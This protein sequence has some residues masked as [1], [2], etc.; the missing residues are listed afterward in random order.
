MSDLEFENKLKSLQDEVE[1]ISKYSRV[2]EKTRLVNIIE[3]L[4]EKYPENA[5]VLYYKARYYERLQDFNTAN[6]LYKKIYEIDP[7]N[8][9]ATIFF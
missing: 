7:N 6:R 3:P 2:E 1:S 5:D 8:D 4:V 9:C